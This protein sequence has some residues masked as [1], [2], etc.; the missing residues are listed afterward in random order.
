MSVIPGQTIF[1]EV[2]KPKKYYI[3]NITN[4]LNAVVTFTQDHDYVIGQLVS[5]RCTRPYGMFEINEKRGQIQRLTANT[6]TV[7]I[8]TNNFTA[9]IYPVSG[10]NTPPVCVPAGSGVLNGTMILTDAYDI[11]RPT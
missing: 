5:F 3:S 9:F 7:D 1:T 4:S 10:K 8:N 2:P 11:L 6:I